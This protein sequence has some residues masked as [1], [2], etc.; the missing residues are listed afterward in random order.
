MINTQ[1]RG[2]YRSSEE[3]I[4]LESLNHKQGCFDNQN[5]IT[6]ENHFQLLRTA[7]FANSDSPPSKPIIKMVQFE[8]ALSNFP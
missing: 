8:E 2:Q 3:R 6:F 1:E 4:S 5:L 7:K